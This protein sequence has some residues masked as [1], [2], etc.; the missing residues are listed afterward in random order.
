M[1]NVATIRQHMAALRKHIKETTGGTEKPSIRYARA[2]ETALQWVLED[3]SWTPISTVK[4]EARMFD[5]KQ[6]GTMENNGVAT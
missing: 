2:M 3:C 1:K 4:G 6:E 5:G